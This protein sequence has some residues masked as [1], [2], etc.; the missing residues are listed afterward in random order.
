MKKEYFF[1]KITQYYSI[2]NVVSF[3]KI[4]VLFEVFIWLCHL[5]NYISKYTGLLNF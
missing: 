2:V 1:Y 3:V 4:S 5:N